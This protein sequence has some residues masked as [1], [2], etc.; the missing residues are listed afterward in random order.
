MRTARSETV[1]DGTDAFLSLAARDVRQGT[2]IRRVGVGA[3]LA[4]PMVARGAVVGAITFATSKNIHAFRQSDLVLAEDVARCCAIA[5]DRARLVAAARASRNTAETALTA[6]RAAG[7]LASAVAER[8]V[9]ANVREQELTEVAEDANRAKSQFLANMS[10]EIRTPIN[11]IVGYADLLDL[12]IPG[13]LNDAQKLHLAR[14][15]ASSN[16]LI[17]LV[18]DVLDLAKLE[19]GH[20][21]VERRRASAADTAAASIE[22]LRTQAAAAGVSIEEP[23]L[24]GDG[25]FYFGD[26][27][28]AQQI[29]VNLLSNAVKF[30]GRGGRVTV[31]AGSTDEPE[32]NAHLEHRDQWTY[33]RVNDTGIG[34]PPDQV[35][36]VF[37]PFVQVETG[38]TRTRG[39]TGLGLTIA[40][41]LAVRM[42]GDLTLRSEIGVGSAFT[43]WL[44]ANG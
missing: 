14:I 35:T 3:L 43:L 17:M 9:M 6:M 44:P 33:I 1:S 23:G 34:I 11:A 40:R 16:H 10:H 20:I 32:S 37:Q 30:T 19:A 25:P 28:R 18:E 31:S 42:G 2:A 12:E 36:K 26:E 39:G 4:V 27:R 15:R 7:R 24:D 29:L 8:L 22:L 41:E 5:V 38:H 21:H 13:P